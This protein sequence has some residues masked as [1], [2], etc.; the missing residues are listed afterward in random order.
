VTLE[1]M[2]EQVV[3]LADLLRPGLRAVVVGINPSPVSVAAGHYYQG[4]FGKRFFARLGAAGV[5]PGGAGFEDDRAFAAGIGF[6][7]VVK[8]PTPR[9]HALRPGEFDHGRDLLEAK[10]ATLGVPK[11]LF[12]YKRA[13]QALLGTFEGHAALRGRSL[14]GAEVF[15]MPGPMERTD[16][17]ERALDE[18]REWWL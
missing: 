4:L 14:A 17:V 12:T 11:V 13:A 9:A 3:T 16:R 1:W 10:L 6:T 8:R 5:L 2:G 18:L 15:V 7:D